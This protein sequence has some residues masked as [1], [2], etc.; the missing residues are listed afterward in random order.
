MIKRELLKSR[1]MELFYKYHNQHANKQ[2]PEIPKYQL[3]TIATENHVKQLKW[4][5]YEQFPAK[6]NQLNIE[7]DS[8][9]SRD[10][11]L[12][13]SSSSSGESLGGISHWWINVNQSLSH[14]NKIV[15]GD[16]QMG[17]VAPISFTKPADVRQYRS[18]YQRNYKPYVASENATLL[19]ANGLVRADVAE[20]TGK[21]MMTT[22][23]TAK[24][25]EKALPARTMSTSFGCLISRLLA[26]VRQ[27]L[28]SVQECQIALELIRAPFGQENSYDG[29]LLKA[30]KSIMHEVAKSTRG[31]QNN[32]L[33]AHERR[34]SNIINLAYS[35]QLVDT[36]CSVASKGEQLAAD[37]AL[38]ATLIRNNYALMHQFAMKNR[39]RFEHMLNNSNNKN[40]ET[41]KN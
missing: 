8:I 30:A 18:L 11:L 19:L 23:A 10:T 1:I 15:M 37:V 20:T 5:L 32:L 26:E 13:I 31:K 29:K 14:D 16:V 22:T 28:W 39:T 27:L 21:N 9:Y 12:K 17:T 7:C 33:D 41:I 24:G 35:P 4:H 25:Q 36:R 34:A 38:Y 6:V 2:Q 40:N 3:I